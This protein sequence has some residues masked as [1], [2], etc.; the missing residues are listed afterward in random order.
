LC[1]A[2]AV[3]LA[4]LAW[5]NGLP[6]STIYTEDLQVTN[7]KWGSN[8][9]YVDIT[10]NNTGTQSVTL[11]SITANAQSAAVV[12]I[13]GSNQI[14]KGENAVLRISNTFT[15]GASCKFTFQTAKGNKFVYM[16]TAEPFSSI[17]KMEQGNTNSR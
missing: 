17:S 14:R 5:I 7:H 6:T 8:C 2:I 11:K 15:P 16:A 9:T 12:Y 1:I 13:V 10:L 3:S 4:T